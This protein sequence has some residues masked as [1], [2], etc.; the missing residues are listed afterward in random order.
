MISETLVRRTLLFTFFYNVMGFAAFMWPAQFGQMAR[1]P[2]DVQFLYQAFVATNIL[3]FGFVGLWMSRQ[4]TL[5]RPL[6]VVFGISK[7]LFSVLMFV[8]WQLGQVHVV[9]F[10]M[11]FVDFAMGLIFLAGA[12]IRQS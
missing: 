2:T 3:L 11:S 8:A 10:L 4:P 7:C 5:D 9:G 1:L 6:L 12:R